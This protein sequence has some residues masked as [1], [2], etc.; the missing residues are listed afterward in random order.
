MEATLHRSETNGISER[1]LRS[2]KEG[3]SAELLHSG[4]MKNGGA[5]MECGS[6]LRNVQELLADGKTSFERRFGE[7]CKWPDIPFGAMLK[8]HPISA[9]A[10]SG[11]FLGY[12]LIAGGFW[13]G[14]IFVADRKIW[15]RQKFMF[16][17]STQKK[18]TLNITSNLEFSSTC[19]KKKHSVFHLKYID[20]FRST[21]TDLD[22]LQEKRIDDYWKVDPNRHLS[23]S[24]K[25]FTKFTLLREKPPKRY[26][27]M[28]GQKFGRKLVTP[29]RIENN[30]NGQKKNQSSTML[31]D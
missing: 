31:E 29:L 6:H 17:G 23:D 12:V 21:H 1:A 8:C 7:P 13:K 22:V 11:I 4:L 9:K 2:M 20:V 10:F 15:T 25:G 28:Y 14:D 27:I 30:R 18:F 5:Y 24:W 26:Q 19:L 16:E 3:T